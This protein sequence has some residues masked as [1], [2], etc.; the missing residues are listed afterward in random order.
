VSIPVD[1][2]EQARAIAEA[3]NVPVSEVF[4]SA[5]I[6]QQAARARLAQRAAPGSRENFLAVLD[7]APDIDPAACDRLN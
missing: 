4:A 7:K 2:F 6:D 3:E 5:F 1:I